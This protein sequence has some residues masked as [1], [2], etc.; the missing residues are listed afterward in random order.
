MHTRK[1]DFSLMGAAGDSESTSDYAMAP[2]K[3]WGR[4]SRTAASAH[5]RYRGVPLYGRHDPVVQDRQADDPCHRNA[6]PPWRHGTG[7]RSRV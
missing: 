5:W 1:G 3:A 2:A 6:S 4:R 7:A